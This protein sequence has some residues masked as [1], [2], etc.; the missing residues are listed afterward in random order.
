MQLDGG[1]AIRSTDTILTFPFAQCIKNF[2]ST[3][4]SLSF[5]ATI[6]II[7][8]MT[9]H[10]PLGQITLHYIVTIPLSPVI[11]NRC[12]TILFIK[13]KK[14]IFLPER[15]SFFVLYSLLLS[16][17]KKTFIHSHSTIRI[18]IL[19]TTTT[20]TIIPITKKIHFSYSCK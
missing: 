1:L 12:C 13:E 2:Y 10:C 16:I 6:S 5:T 17:E 11:K 4:L 19:I 8:P 9:R 14:G 7:I 15:K 18:V 3:F 20:S